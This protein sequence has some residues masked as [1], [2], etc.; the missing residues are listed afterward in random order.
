MCLLTQDDEGSHMFILLGDG[1]RETN[2]HLGTVELAWC[3]ALF[4]EPVNSI[5]AQAQY[6]AS[7]S[8]R[9]LDRNWS[10]PG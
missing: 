3:G 5:T 9:L 2:V 1:Q 6:S 8:Q 10:V 7:A 4:N